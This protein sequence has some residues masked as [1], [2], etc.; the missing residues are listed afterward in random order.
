MKN[1]LV[2]IFVTLL[3]LACGGP[4]TAQEIEL[5]PEMKVWE[6]MLGTWSGTTETRQSPTDAWT[7]STVEWEV[8]SGGY[9]LEH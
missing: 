3:I 5:T 1:G 6:P 2:I 9:Y 8:R 7:N 4:A